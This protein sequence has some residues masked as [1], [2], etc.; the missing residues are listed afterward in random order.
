[1]RKYLFGAVFILLSIPAYA[2]TLNPGDTVPLFGTTA[3]MSPET[4]GPILEEQV[5]NF[6]VEIN[7]K[8]VTGSVS[9]RLRDFQGFGLLIDY[10]ITS[11]VD[12]GLGL[13]IQGLNTQDFF[14]VS[15]LGPLDVDYRLDEPGDIFPETASLQAGFGGPVEYDFGSNPLLAGET[16]R[17]MFVGDPNNDLVVFGNWGAQLMVLD[18][19]DKQFSIPFNSYVTFIPV[20][21]AVWLFA[22]GLIG[23]IGVARR[24]KA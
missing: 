20:P 18:P 14:G 2:V 10:R 22:S 17:W 6:A 7:G 8:M 21:A 5:S 16:S 23:L 9:Q 13:Q 11:F 24:K 4:A 12:Q 15:E 1:M 19:A 3:I